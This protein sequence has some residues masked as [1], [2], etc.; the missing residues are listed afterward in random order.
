M[1]FEVLLKA[2]LS[3]NETDSEMS[4]TYSG[5]VPGW[6]AMMKV[7]KKPVSWIGVNDIQR[8]RPE[9]AVANPGVVKSKIPAECVSKWGTPCGFVSLSDKCRLKPRNS[10]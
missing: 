4:V 5:T 7:R 10:G 1:L 3:R 6:S 9:S 2:I 8:Y